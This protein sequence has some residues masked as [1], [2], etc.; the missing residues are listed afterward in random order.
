MHKPYVFDIDDRFCSD[1]NII[2]I[3]NE[4]RINHD[5]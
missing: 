4:F 5:L 2:R 3:D 1:Y